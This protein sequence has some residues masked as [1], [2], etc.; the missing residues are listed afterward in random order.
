MD[1]M[2]LYRGMDIGTAKPTAGGPRRVPHHLID[3][4]DPWESA[5]V[6][7]WL[8]RAAAAVADIEA[9]GKTA[10]FVGG[11]PLYLKALLCGLFDGPP[12]D[13]ETCGRGSRRRPSAT[14]GSAARAARRGRSGDGRAAAPERRPPR[15]AG[16]GGLATDRAGRSA[17]GSSRT[18]GTARRPPVPTGSCLVA[19]PAAAG[20]VRPH[21]PARRGD[22]RR[23]AGRGGPPRCAH[24]RDRSSREAAQ[25]LGYRELFDFLD[26][27]PTLGETDRR[28]PDADPAVRQAAADLVPRTCPG[29]S[30]C[31]AN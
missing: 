2:T 20:A 8:E 31:D 18:G 5:S 24:C 15:G 9:R 11:T 26:G 13:Q 25:A 14:A 28:D 19:R 29:A 6:A 16:P 23:R 10:L 27:K 4:L 1:S 3:V 17:T 30:S 21:R 7:W 12:A 22:V